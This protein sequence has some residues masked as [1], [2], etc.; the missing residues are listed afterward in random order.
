MLSVQT[1]YCWTLGRQPGDAVPLIR[2]HHVFIGC[3]KPGQQARNQ[4]MNVESA[5]ALWRGK[6]IQNATSP[7][8]LDQ[9]FRIA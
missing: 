8:C 6:R 5:I 1:T 4:F 2:R 3:G 9:Q 7:L